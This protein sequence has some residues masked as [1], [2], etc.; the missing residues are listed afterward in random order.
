MRVTTAICTSCHIRAVELKP[1]A[2][3]VAPCLVANASSR[4][5]TAWWGTPDRA[6]ASAS[7]SAAPRQSATVTAYPAGLANEVRYFMT[8]L[9]LGASRACLDVNTKA[10]AA[11]E[12]A[13]ALFPPE[14]WAFSSAYPQTVT[15]WMR[16]GAFA[17]NR[18][19]MAK[20]LPFACRDA[21]QNPGQSCSRAVE[22]VVDA[23]TFSV[24][25]VARPRLRCYGQ[26]LP[27]A[28]ARGLNNPLVATAPPC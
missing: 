11:A 24:F 25:R 20:G 4:I 2:I 3:P 5:P 12:V 23:L 10:K 18:E 21:T 15:G 17:F 14:V 27:P 22:G 6:S 26:L 28:C 16:E 19:V 8:G 7:A 9:L 1:K 13:L